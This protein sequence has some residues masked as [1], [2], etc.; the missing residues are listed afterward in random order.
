MAP[1]S[2]FCGSDVSAIDC[3]LVSAADHTQVCGVPLPSPTTALA[4][5]SSVKEFA[6]SGPP[7]LSCFQM[8]NWPKAGTSMPV[9]ISGAA[10]IFANGCTSTNLTIEV[11][12]VKRTGD[13][14]DGELDQLVGK[15]VTTPA[16]CTTTST[17]DMTSSCM[18]RYNCNYTY[19]MVPSET[20]LAIKTYGTVWA[21]LYDYN[22]YISN[23]DVKGGTWA[24]DVRALAADDYTVI[25]QTALGAP[26]TP[27]HGAVAG[28]V[29]DCG[30]V[31]LIGATVDVDVGRK[32]LTYF[33][34]DEA[35]P[36]PDTSATSTSTLGLYA[37]MDIAPGPVGVGALGLVGG[38]ITT[39]GYYKVRAYA[40]S[41][42]S[43]TFHGLTPVQVHP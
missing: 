39:V 28:E 41:V 36:L 40:D 35:N 2:A 27:G 25:A 38:S 17:M 34:T 14:H 13:A 31:R 23:A 15:S 3:S 12:T 19:P 22:I 20:E 16:D 6:G 21:P 29:H 10:R 11:Y 26:I 9:T 32:L 43:I 5:S 1:G 18:L 7:D 8:A 37:A 33:T 42:T 24:H 30:D 4:R